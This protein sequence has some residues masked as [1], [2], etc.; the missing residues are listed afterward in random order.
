MHGTIIIRDLDE[1]VVKPNVTNEV[2]GK[3]YYKAS[4]GV[5][6]TNGLKVYFN[7]ELDPSD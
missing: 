6:F 3:K 1:T 2:V 4:N 5:K 7:G